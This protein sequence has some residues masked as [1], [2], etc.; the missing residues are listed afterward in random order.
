MD[1][2]Y[3][4]G[5]DLTIETYLMHL[6][7]EKDRIM[8]KSIG[9]SKEELISFSPVSPLSNLLVDMLF[10][11]GYEYLLSNKMEKA[12]LALLNFGGIRAALP[13]G[14]ITIGDIYQIT[15]FDNT[16]TL[17]FVKGSELQKMFNGFTEKRN[18]PMANVQTIYGNGKLD[19]YTIGGAP[20]AKDKV[21]TMV[22]INFLALGGDGFLKGVNFESVIY[23]D[24]SLRDVFI[25]EIRR[26]D[27]QGIKIE[28]IRDDRVI[29]RPT[30]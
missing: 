30:P 23:L 2:T 12:D 1:S 27:A 22:T 15:P 19:S 7:Q 11:W 10:E 21:Y 24:T 29:I 8:D 26:K 6:K 16:V 9:T 14:R 25:E 28:M 17:V 13:Q 5:I 20:L 4:Q 3:D 18:A